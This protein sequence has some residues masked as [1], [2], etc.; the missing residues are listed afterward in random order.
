MILNTFKK[1]AFY[2]RKS[3]RMH[4]NNNT[5]LLLLYYTFTTQQLNNNNLFQVNKIVINHKPFN[6]ISIQ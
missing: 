5:G 6:I 2:S 1:N 4:N 3:N